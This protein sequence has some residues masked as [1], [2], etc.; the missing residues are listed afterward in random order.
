MLGTYHVTKETFEHFASAKTLSI[1]G[2]RLSLTHDARIELA[3]GHKIALRQI[4]IDLGETLF[5]ILSGE[6]TWKV[7]KHQEYSAVFVTLA[8]LQPSAK[9]CPRGEF[10]FDLELFDDSSLQ[11][12]SKTKYPLLHLT[13]GDPDSGD[14]LQFEKD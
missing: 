5:C 10:G 4:P 6:G 7:D 12:H 14:A 1:P 8:N 13:I 11:F 2:G 9:G 3:T